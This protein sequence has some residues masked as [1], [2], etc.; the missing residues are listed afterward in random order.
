[1]AT[2][3]TAIPVYNGERFIA[4]TLACLAA[5]TRKPDRLVILDNGSTDRTKEMVAAAAGLQPEYRLNE[6]NLGMFG[7]MN[8]ALDLAPE[9]DYLHVLHADD[10]IKPSFYQ[11][12]ELLLA[13]M[14]GRGLAYAQ[15]D[16]IDEMG[17]PSRLGH[18][19]RTDFENCQDVDSFLR[20]RAELQPI[21]CPA[22]LLKTGRE[23][24]PVHFR[25]D[26]PQLA[27]LVFWAEWAHATG[28]VANHPDV[29]A[30]YRVHSQSGTA[31]NATNLQSFVLDEWR[32]MQLI[33]PLRCR[34]HTPS[35]WRQEKLRL[36]FAARS[37]VKAS[38]A[39]PM[40]ARLIRQ[41]A[42]RHT[43]WLPV[44]LA[45]FLVGLRNGLHYLRSP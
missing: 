20:V 41:A 38:G 27:D 10:L 6:R 5:Q 15:S 26:M 45:K 25:E 1:M 37:L 9:T 40:Q 16:F 42:L 4:A 21:V 17:A 22:V 19:H 34:N 39:E 14:P 32:A 3:I 2:L 13:K 12:L 11:E 44:Q 7:N 33:E 23:Q 31:A 8:R 29:L 43:G 24:A 35:R 18:R 36:I 30:H 28:N